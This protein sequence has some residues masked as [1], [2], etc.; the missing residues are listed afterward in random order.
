MARNPE[1]A[2]LDGEREPVGQLGP[3]PWRLNPAT[4]AVVAAVTAEGGQARFVGGCVRDSLLHR[5]TPGM[6]ID[7]AVTETP[8]RVMALLAAR[9]IK[10]VPT[11][12]SHGTV[13]AV[14]D[15]LPHE[16]TTLR[17]DI[18]CDGRH[19][20]VDFTTSFRE[21]AKRRD[22]TFNALSADLDGRVYDYFDGIADLTEGRVRF[23]GRAMDRIR[24]DYLRILRFF[25]F[26][27]RYGIPPADPDGL[28]AC[29]ALA[30]GLDGLSGERVRV[31]LLK[32]LAVDDPVGVLGLMRGARVLD[33]VLPESGD[34]APLRALVLLETRGLVLPG[35]GV[36]PIR[37][38]ACAI[39]AGDADRVRTLAD[40]LRL[41]RVQGERLRVLATDAGPPGG[42]PA[43][44]PAPWRRMV[45]ARGPA[46]VVD[47]LL[48]AW[49]LE[50]SAEMRPRAARSD[51]W[52]ARLEATLAWED[53][54]FPLTGAD[55]LARGLSG[56]AIGALLARLR[57]AW[58]DDD[59][60][61][62]RDAAL[63]RMDAA[64][65]RDPSVGDPS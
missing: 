10:V 59:R 2:G 12:L 18:S 40:R 11:G 8:D 52:R 16:V 5:I 36:D 15:G 45:D 6:D 54:P 26:F 47:G 13:T 9:G 55:A 38:L 34:L 56:P 44:D 4:R 14:A 43:G 25:R 21:D 65:V 42:D 28:A 51:Q 37:R 24:E 23:I 19:A 33:R 58:L 39:G 57:G 7:I 48:L 17:R 27:G 1:R 3:D 22:F 64:L 61:W 30:Q 29:A 31:E 60:T 41:S 20:E 49:A 62:N 46:A 32:I 35:V 50:R 63:A 53:R